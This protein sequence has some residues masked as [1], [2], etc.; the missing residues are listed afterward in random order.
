MGLLAFL[1][2]TA[3]WAAFL[4]AGTGYFCRKKKRIAA[5][6]GWACFYLGLAL[7]A[8]WSALRILNSM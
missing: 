5:Y 7:F 6:A 2:V 8:A 4:C 1:S 3:F